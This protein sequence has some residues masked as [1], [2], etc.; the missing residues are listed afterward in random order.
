MVIERS[1]YRAIVAVM[2]FLCG[3]R[4]EL[5]IR[6]GFTIRIVA[7]V[8][9]EVRCHPFPP[10]AFVAH[11]LPAVIVSATASNVHLS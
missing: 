10:P 6:M 9:A 5:R 11:P 4:H 1:V 7:L 3:I 8:L 2:S